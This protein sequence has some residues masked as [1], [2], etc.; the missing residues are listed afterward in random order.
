MIHF[1]N[2]KSSFIRRILSVIT[3]SL[4]TWNTLALGGGVQQ[5]SIPESQVSTIALP[6]ELG[7]IKHIFNGSKKGLV[8]HIQD[9]HVNHEAQRSLAAIIDFFASGY[10]ARLVS[11]EGASGE[12]AHHLLSAFPDDSIRK[13]VADYF[14]R[15]AF[16]S[17]PEYLA[18]S[19]RKDLV[20][21]GAEDKV[22]YETNRKTFLD[23]LKLQPKDQRIL[24]EVR[25]IMQALGRY[26]FKE[27]LWKLIR[28]KSFFEGRGEWDLA[29]YVRYLLKTADQWKVAHRSP[30]IEILMKLV[31]LENQRGSKDTR[32][33]V[34]WAALSNG[35]NVGIFDE[36]RR[37]EQALEEKMVTSDKERKL[38]RL[39]RLL[40]VY[41]KIFDFS[42]TKEDAEFF[43]KHRREFNSETFVRALAPL[44]TTYHFDQ[45]IRELS[46]DLLDNDLPRFETFYQLALKRDDILISNTLKKMK[47][48]R[49]NVSVI[50]TGGFHTP[51][52]EKTLQAKGISYLV[53][54]P[55]LVQHV[56]KISESKRY[57]QAMHSG[58]T[59]L[60]KLLS[61][62]YA[63]A[64]SG[65]VN[66]PHYQIGTPSRIPTET[67]LKTVLA[68]ESLENFNPAAYF[69][70]FPFAELPFIWAEFS[71]SI[72]AAQGKELR[73]IEGQL[74]PQIQ[75]NVLRKMSASLSPAEKK[76]GPFFYASLRGER[77]PTGPSRGI[78]R[79]PNLSRGAYLET[80]WSLGDNPSEVST[81][82]R[83]ARFELDGVHLEFSLRRGRKLDFETAARAGALR[84]EVRSSKPGGP[85]EPLLSRDY[86]APERFVDIYRKL[87]EGNSRKWKPH[88]MIALLMLYGM[89]PNKNRTE[90][91]NFRPVPPQIENAFVEHFLPAVEKFH[92]RVVE[93]GGEGH[94]FAELFQQAYRLARSSSEM[95]NHIPS[96]GNKKGMAPLLG[97]FA[98]VKQV[99]SDRKGGFFGRPEVWASFR[100]QFRQ[101]IM[102]SMSDF[103]NG[104]YQLG[105]IMTDEADLLDEK[106]FAFPKLTQSIKENL[107][108]EGLSLASFIY[109]RAH[110][111]DKEGKK[112]LKLKDRKRA[113]KRVYTLS[114][115]TPEGR[116][117][118]IL[119]VTQVQ[120]NGDGRIA[121]LDYHLE[122]SRELN[123]LE[124]I[125]RNAQQAGDNASLHQIF[126]R[127]LPSFVR[128]GVA[129]KPPVQNG[130]HMY[131]LR[132][133]AEPV[134]ILAGIRPKELEAEP[135]VSDPDWNELYDSEAGGDPY[136]L[137]VNLGQPARQKVPHHLDDLLDS[138]SD[139][140]L[141]EDGEDFLEMEEPISTAGAR[142]V[143]SKGVP[144]SLPPPIEEVPSYA[145]SEELLQEVPPL[146]ESLPKETP[147]QIA[148][149]FVASGVLGAAI[150][151]GEAAGKAVTQNLGIEKKFLE[152]SVRSLGRQAVQRILDQARP[153]LEQMKNAKPS[154]IKT[155]TENLEGVI[156]QEFMPIREVINTDELKKMYIVIQNDL[157]TQLEPLV[158]QALGEMN[159]E[160][161]EAVDQ[162]LPQLDEKV[163]ALEVRLDEPAQPS[164]QRKL[165]EKREQDALM[166]LER[167]RQE[168]SQQVELLNQEVQ[169]LE[170]KLAEQPEAS[171]QMPALQEEAVRL[172]EQIETRD[173]K[174]VEQLDTAQQEITKLQGELERRRVALEE[175][176]Q[177]IE[178]ETQALNQR[179]QEMEKS[180]SEIEQTKQELERRRQY[181]DNFW[182]DLQQRGRE[183]NNLLR[184]VEQSEAQVQEMREALT[185]RR[186]M[187]DERQQR[188]RESEEEINRSREEEEIEGL[189]NVRSQELG[190]AKEK[191]SDAGIPLEALQGKKFQDVNALAEAGRKI[192]ELYAILKTSE[193]QFNRKTPQMRITPGMLAMQQID[194]MKEE[195]VEFESTA[196]YQ[197]FKKEEERLVKELQKNPVF[198][199]NVI[200]DLYHQFGR[201]KE[202]TIKRLRENYEDR[203]ERI[204][205]TIEI[206]KKL[207]DIADQQEA[208]TE[209]D[210]GNAESLSREFREV[211]SFPGL[212]QAGSPTSNLMS[213]I[214]LRWLFQKVSSLPASSFNAPKKL[215]E[216]ETELKD[217]LRP[218]GKGGLAQMQDNQPIKKILM[219]IERQMTH[220][221]MGV[222][223]KSLADTQ[224]MR[225][226]GEKAKTKE[227][228]N[229]DEEMKAPAENREEETIQSGSADTEQ[230][231]GSS[232][233]IELKPPTGESARSEQ[234]QV[235][236][237][238]SFSL[239]QREVFQSSAAELRVEIE[240]LKADTNQKTA[241]TRADK[242]RSKISDLPPGDVRDN[243]D[244]DFGSAVI[245]VAKKFG[246]KQRSEVRK[247]GG[248]YRR[249]LEAIASKDDFEREQLLNRAVARFRGHLIRQTIFN[250]FVA[251]PLNQ[252]G[253]TV[254][255]WKPYYSAD[256]F[257]RILTSQ[258][259]AAIAVSLGK[260]GFAP[261]ELLYLEERF[262]GR[263]FV[264]QGSVNETAALVLGKLKL[265]PAERI[266]LALTDDLSKV[267]GERI[268][269]LLAA[270]LIKTAIGFAPG[271]V[272]VVSDELVPSDRYLDISSGDLVEAWFAEEKAAEYTATRA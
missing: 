233:D 261:P 188:V 198:R 205:R 254:F 10:K 222:V 187:L 245:E 11:V 31:D 184:E 39:F 114:V 119:S 95:D 105:G 1:R 104:Q 266:Q 122:S 59:P 228:I 238:A 140:T 112:T 65:R 234:S 225:K 34:E 185:E 131:N 21:F 250:G 67:D 256:D 167:R 182:E 156:D 190:I 226:D 35:I 68:P 229:L 78:L 86:G 19:K 199:G 94:A 14:L 126:G 115:K 43:M 33:D 17:G 44:L 149:S 260:A 217:I 171:T 177:K 51:G 208:L 40:E 224:K 64:L 56:D 143:A 263:F 161:Q 252:R 61:E 63:P 235:E 53:I 207:R 269:K 42:L 101:D 124:E 221:R 268:R 8:I 201:M 107:I 227:S 196:E 130:W 108:H 242:I 87:S 236:T 46:L 223:E 175:Q 144:S 216:Y 168:E 3:A 248:N 132:I 137:G 165:L 246:S 37:L 57:T 212:S 194:T 84:S 155:L 128:I 211:S 12:L 98:A 237:F 157:A 74:R 81:L 204:N 127:R 121:Q 91:Q 20:L 251:R 181:A 214:Q 192:Q 23:A 9:A 267:E 48:A 16:I 120:S 7:E 141:V 262:A 218:F 4:F 38:A 209:K 13:K 169:K 66:D 145:V 255:K 96:Y 36:I 77:Y 178:Q 72:Y 210:W 118:F 253:L 133:E 88:E 55:R 158:D 148:S 92:R 99:F 28:S 249:M 25:K 49:Q 164:Q 153:I 163:K 193:D 134:E 5:I 113:A 117:Y 79:G 24:A 170:L 116:K 138:A 152:A 30:Q 47:E 230:P 191:A 183:V 29:G 166:E 52:I 154:G 75:E 150:R 176:R 32:D 93:P 247:M 203:R 179:N 110:W 272:I 26:V 125:L 265:K 103:F 41:E 189:E 62:A 109:R 45:D 58:L 100:K 111:I 27:D 54:A 264:I 135:Q 231:V 180:E 213:R 142:N 220:K 50:V 129:P 89:V 241:K 162:G 70:Q 160:I 18:L 60:G 243:I 195:S 173:Q 259:R 90:A 240:K 85:F 239:S 174:A 76:W 244:D 219:E 202:M 197:S 257:E 146:L 186:Q 6:L 215:A 2:E 159:E 106:I 151:G 102:E 206:W 69:K 139:F 258:P 71:S 82:K 172:Q 147:V 73:D 97:L 232:P 271:N 22:L 136:A 83:G 123:R 270:A 200:Q 80:V 15:E